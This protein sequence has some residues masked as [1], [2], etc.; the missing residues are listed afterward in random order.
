MSTFPENAI[1]RRFSE[2]NVLNLLYTQAEIHDL[3]Q[4]VGNIRLEDYESGDLSRMTYAQ[5][6]RSIRDNK[7]EGDS[8]QYDQLVELGK[9]L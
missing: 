7:V 4:Q 5:D 2:L 6:F 3:E 1:S 8:E 9:K